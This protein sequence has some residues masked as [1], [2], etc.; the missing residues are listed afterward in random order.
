MDHP[1]GVKNLDDVISEIEGRLDEKDEVR[2]LTI[3]SSRTIARLSGS[4]IQAM[5]RGHDVGTALKE[6][7]KEILKL[8]NVLKD[9]PDLYHT[10]TVE[11]AMQEAGEAFLVHAILFQDRVDEERLARFL[12]R[13]LNGP[14]VVQV[15]MVLQE[16]PQLQDL[17]PGLLESRADIV[18]A[19]HC[20]NRTAAQSR[21]RA[22]GLDRQ[23]PDLVLLVQP[24]LDLGDDVIEILHE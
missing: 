2:E 23:L 21:D 6:T 1:R 3:K 10:G 16:A 20:L 4:G 19:M 17:L 14:G 13:V 22:G 12:H 11:N 5:H 18:P 24:A 8:R 7:R 15:R 9:H